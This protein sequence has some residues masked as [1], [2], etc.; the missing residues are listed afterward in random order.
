[1]VIPEFN[2]PKGPLPRHDDDFYWNR[3]ERGKPGRPS[4]WDRVARRNELS[5]R[6]AYLTGGPASAIDPKGNVYYDHGN[7]RPYMITPWPTMVW[8][9]DATPPL[10]DPVLDA[11]VQKGIAETN[12]ALK[13]YPLKVKKWIGQG[14]HGSVSLCEY[15]PRPGQVYE[16]IVKCPK[17]NLP[18]TMML[19]ARELFMLDVS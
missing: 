15:T 17:G 6:F 4:L 10:Q 14:G 1:M 18:G 7:I 12:A 3:L 5:G 16:C 8:P 11:K 13:H 2:P 9:T 19:L